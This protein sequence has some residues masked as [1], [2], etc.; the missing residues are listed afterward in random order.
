[1]AAARKHIEDLYA[2][3]LSPSV[4]ASG[5]P[6]P[7]EDVLNRMFYY[8]FLEKFTVTSSDEIKLYSG[9]DRVILITPHRN[10]NPNGKYYAQYCKFQI[11]LYVPWKGGRHV[12][13]GCDPLEE[14]TDEYVIAK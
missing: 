5:T 11:L 8:E 14:P 1:M 12:V 7:S 13:W 3:R 10:S 4:W 6:K 2:D 9:P